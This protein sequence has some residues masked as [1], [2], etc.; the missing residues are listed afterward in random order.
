MGRNNHLV[1]LGCGIL[2]L[3]CFVEELLVVVAGLFIVFEDVGVCVGDI[4]IGGDGAW[5][6][7]QVFLPGFHGFRVVL[8]QIIAL[9]LGKGNRLHDGC[10]R[11]QEFFG[12]VQIVQPLRIPF[13][14]DADHTKT[15][16]TARMLHAADEE[17]ELEI[18]ICSLKVL[19]L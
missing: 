11:T 16:G 12:E 4:E 6:I 3:S 9:A 10:I 7:R 13:G 18:L 14:I 19:Y 17:G 15:I 8:G 1:Q 2:Y 5:I